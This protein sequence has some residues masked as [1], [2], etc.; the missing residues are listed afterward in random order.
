MEE[1]HSWEEIKDAFAG[2]SI[3]TQ[4]SI[5]L[6]LKA[7]LSPVDYQ[8]LVE[9]VYFGNTKLSAIQAL[10]REIEARANSPEKEKPIRELKTSKADVSRNYDF[11]FNLPKQTKDLT[12]DERTALSNVRLRLFLLE[13]LCLIT[14]YPKGKR[15]N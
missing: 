14:L 5:P 10:C 15:S 12:T 8:K 7:K 2:H 6:S 11:V 1:P 4:L 13:Q 3:E 9:V